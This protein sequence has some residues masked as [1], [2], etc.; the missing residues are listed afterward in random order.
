VNRITKPAVLHWAL[1]L[2]LLLESCLFAFS[3]AQA[4]AF[5]RTGFPQWLRVALG[6]AEA[7]AALLFLMPRT[8]RLGGSFL[9]GIF[10]LAA[11]IHVLH[12][13]PNVGALAIY[14]IAV[15]MVMD[16]YARRNTQAGL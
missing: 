4:H 12:G 6:S 15:L 1:G 3:P 9:L 10:S 2:V 13:S 5:A 16:A 8:V 7:L 14:A 11:V